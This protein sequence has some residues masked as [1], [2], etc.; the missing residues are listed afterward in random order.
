MSTRGSLTGWGGVL[1]A[2]VS[3]AVLGGC[4]IHSQSPIKEVAYDFSDR[5]FYDRA[6]APSPQYTLRSG[7]EGGMPAAQSGRRSAL[8][9]G[10]GGPSGTAEYLAIP[11]GDDGSF[12]LQPKR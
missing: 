2:V 10:A 7:V 1:A 5:D 9:A 4:A 8:V 3:A 11:L 6:Y 12:Q